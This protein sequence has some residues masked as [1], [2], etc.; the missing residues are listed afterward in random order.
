MMQ[1]CVWCMAVDHKEPLSSRAGPRFPQKLRQKSNGRA[2]VAEQRQ[3]FNTSHFV[4]SKQWSGLMAMKV[5]QAGRAGDCSRTTA[6]LSG[7]F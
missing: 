3:P 5:E 6:P 1:T 2:G 7:P 4:D